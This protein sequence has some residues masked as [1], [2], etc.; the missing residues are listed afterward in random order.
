VGISG[1]AKSRGQNSIG[2]RRTRNVDIGC[3]N[4]HTYNFFVCGPKFTNFL[5]STQD[6]LPLTTPLTPFHISMPFRDIRG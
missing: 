3:V 4:L 6:E 2:I 5:C 1:A